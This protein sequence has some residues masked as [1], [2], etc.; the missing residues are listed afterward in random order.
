[1]KRPF[2]AYKGTEPYLFVCY[3]HRDAETVYT[4]LVALDQHGINIWYDE[5][6]PAGSAW[7]GEIAA[8]IKGAEKLLYFISEASLQSKHCLREVDY[9]LTHDIE[10]IPVYLEDVSLPGELDLV[11][12][13][14][15]GLFRE[16][17]SMYM[18]H[19]VGALRGEARLAGAPPARRKPGPRIWL[20]A[21]LAVLSLSALFYWSPWSAKD[22]GSGIDTPVAGAPNAYDHY[23]EGLALL[24]RWDKDDNLEK[25]IGLFREAISLD[26][27]FALAYARLADALR[28][29]YALTGDE[30]RLDQATASVN[31]A[32]RL[33]ADLGPVQ[34][35]LGRVQAAR[36]NFDLATAALERALTIDPNDAVANQAIAGVYAKLGRPE[37]AKV[38]YRRALALDSDNPTIHAAY[39]NFLAHQG[40]MEGAIAAFQTVIRLAP[41]NYAARVNLGSVLTDIGRLPEAIMM[42]QRANAIRPSYMA[43]SNLGTAYSMSARYEEAVEAYNQALEINDSDWLAWGN[44]AYVY[45]WM[46]GQDVRARET[47]EKAI[48]LAEAAKDKSPRDPYIYSDLALYYAKTGQPELALQHV[49]TALVLAPD[50]GEMLA[51]AAEVHELLGRRDQAVDAAQRSLAYGLTWQRLKRNPELSGLLE[52]P[53]MQ[54]IP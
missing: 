45:S 4:D 8:A 48:E 15:H 13:R 37:D 2:P 54:E 32:V 12:N 36:G 10:I 50:S 49:E 20:P 25:A 47:F 51:A 27:D 29:Q 41:D 30:Q 21:L 43:Y 24:E 53:R 3:A 35:A 39:A 17:D 26:P 11:L 19:L 52:D 31:Q 6:I 16:R 22:A 23:L 38:Y 28:V 33:G 40:D 46:G 5:G 7:R 1:L 18:E 44:L 14:V 42:Y 34:V 9:A